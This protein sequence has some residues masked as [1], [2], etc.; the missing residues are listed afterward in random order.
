MDSKSSVRV[1][2]N[3]GGTTAL[4]DYDVD[5]EEDFIKV[6]FASG[7]V[8]K[9][10]D[11]PYDLRSKIYEANR[12][13]ANA[14]ESKFVNV[15]GKVKFDNTVVVLDSFE[16][17]GTVSI[18]TETLQGAEVIL[19]D[20]PIDDT[21]DKDILAKIDLLRDDDADDQN[22]VICSSTTDR[23]QDTDTDDKAY[24]ST[25]FSRSFSSDSDD[26]LFINVIESGDEFKTIMDRN[27][28]TRQGSAI[29]EQVTY[30]PELFT[31][32]QYKMYENCAEKPLEEGDVNIY[33]PKK[34]DAE[35]LR[36]KLKEITGERKRA[37]QVAGASNDKKVDCKPMKKVGCFAS[38]RNVQKKIKQNIKTSEKKVQ[39]SSAQIQQQMINC[40]NGNN[41]N[42]NNNNNNINNNNINKNNKARV[43]YYFEMD[44]KGK[45]KPLNRK[46][47]RQAV[48]ETSSSN[49]CNDKSANR[50]FHINLRAAKNGE[51]AKPRIT[52][53]PNADL[54]L[55]FQTDKSGNNK[56]AKLVIKKKQSTVGEELQLSPT[57]LSGGGTIKKSSAAGSGERPRL[58]GY[59]GLRSEY[60][61]SAEQLLERRNTRMERERRRKELRQKKHEEE[62]KKRAEN[63]KNFY[64]WLQQKKQLKKHAKTI[65]RSYPMNRLTVSSTRVSIN[66]IHDNDQRKGSFALE[67]LLKIKDENSGWFKF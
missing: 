43:T 17:I 58:P 2:S 59:N 26:P 16:D 10:S 29:D 34:L 49:N 37:V 56:G 19:S 12:E 8:L 35:E 39:P 50:F 3:T 44:P 51:N 42:N 38:L 25:S 64:K 67:E 52:K 33:V 23:T 4:N 14:S 61:L 41:N 18:G 1:A 5:D 24:S 27:N 15:P 62:Q 9:P 53:T 45:L 36:N 6:Y 63:E 47:N 31:H 20:R 21:E 11:K 55:E 7:T 32:T 28:K 46:N 30:F 48:D 22:D 57:S 40:S 54:F 65:R 66:S 13:L 60:G